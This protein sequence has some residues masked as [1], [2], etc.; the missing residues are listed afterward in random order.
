MLYAFSRDGA[1][2]LSRWWRKVDPRFE[3]P[4]NAVSALD[5]QHTTPVQNSM[6]CISC[7]AIRPV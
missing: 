3:A 4:V 1:V 6:A 7:A 5:Q 2:P